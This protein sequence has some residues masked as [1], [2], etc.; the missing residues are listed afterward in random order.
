VW[1]ATYIP[2]IPWGGTKY[3]D[4]SKEIFI[5]TESAII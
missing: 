1:S 2:A 3:F 5:L 4:N